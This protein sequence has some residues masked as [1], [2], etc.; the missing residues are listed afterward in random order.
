MYVL[1]FLFVVVRFNLNLELSKVCDSL[2]AGWVLIAVVVVVVVI[3]E[4]MVVVDDEVPCCC[5]N[6]DSKCW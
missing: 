2:L 4:E 6:E 3:V 1:I 5:W